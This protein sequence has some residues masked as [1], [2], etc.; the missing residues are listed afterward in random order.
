MWTEDVNT[1][2]NVSAS[3]NMIYTRGQL[4]IGDADSGENNFDFKTFTHVA[5]NPEYAPYI[6]QLGGRV[7]MT[8]T[9]EWEYEIDT[10][11]A[12]I[13]AL[14][15]GEILKDSVIIESA[16]GTEHTIDIAIHGTNDAPVVSQEAVLLVGTEDTDMRITQVELLTYATDIDHNDINQLTVDNLH[17]D[18][19]SISTN[20]DGNF[21]FSPDK[22]YNG[23]VHFTYDVKD[24]HGGVTNTGATTNLAA[25]NDVSILA[26]PLASAEV[27]E[28][29]TPSA[30]SNELT[31][32][33]NNLD[34][35]DV[36]GSNE[37]DIVQIEINGVVHQIPAD[38]A[39]NL[40]GDHGFFT[41]T[42]SSDS[43]NKWRYTADNSNPDI[44]GLK[45]G[46]SLTDS[47]TLI[48]A[49]GTRIPIIAT[50]KGIDDN[51]IIDT[52]ASTTASLG[53][54]I[55][56]SKTSVSGV[57]LAHD[58][59]TDD[60]VHFEA[61]STT[62]IYGAL[63]V[64]KDGTWH[65]D[66]DSS[67]ANSLGAGDFKA[68]GFD[69]VAISSDGSKATQHIQVTVQ[70]TNDQAVITGQDSA[71]VTE[72]VNARE[73]NTVNKLAPIHHGIG[74]NGVLTVTDSDTGE[75]HFY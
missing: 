30:I 23:V 55:E 24:S 66:L 68:E 25:V 40:Q 56:D 4:T 60:S 54:L 8:K 72:D 32:F 69:V 22:N 58:S 18:H 49:D 3:A 13:Q 75:A 28:D 33:W 19:G 21:T 6:S 50:I 9:G 74:T 14:G 44:Q 29:N 17:V 7:S 34:T 52:P 63:S 27:T 73:I 51:V 57:L 20:A 47:M 2:S 16:D 12:N 48:T 36:D 43:H 37:A 26:S 67:K 10:T 46:Q 1:Y 42:H 5:T 71:L 64:N 65:Y 41:T 62:G 70:G 59:D 35:T 61:Q 39:L 53:T 45:D 31:S 11:K 15:A 38:F